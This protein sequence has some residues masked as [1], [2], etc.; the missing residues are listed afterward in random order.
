[1]SEQRDRQVPGNR[2]RRPVGILFVLILITIIISAFVQCGKPPAAVRELP[3]PASPAAAASETPQV[4]PAMKPPVPSPAPSAASAAPS[5]SPG[6]SKTPERPVLQEYAGRFKENDDFIAWLS[7]SGTPIDYPVM[8]SPEDHDY[9]LTHNFKK[10]KDKNGLLV[11]QADCDPYTPGTNLIIHGHNMKSGKMFGTLDKYNNKA[12]WRKH[13]TIRFDTLYEK[14]TYRIVSVFLSKVYEE[15][16]KG[17]MYYRFLNAATEAE[18]KDFYKNVKNMS[19]YDTRV[20]AKFGDTFITLST[21][22]YQ[23]VNGRFVVVAKKVK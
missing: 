11:L 13:P 1:M 18:F 21:C 23:A 15:D 10:K 16:Y 19:L 4:S 17:F 20:D 6:P 7:I 12:Y 3:A 5:V 22:Y 14:G 8:Y 2:I 9:Y